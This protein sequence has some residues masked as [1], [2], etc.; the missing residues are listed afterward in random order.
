MNSLLEIKHL[1]KSYHKD[2]ILKDINIKIN[3]GDIYGLIGPNG[4]GKSTTVKTV[5]GLVKKDSGEVYFDGKLI[6]RNSS[7]NRLIG[8]TIEE[9]SFY[10][11]LSGYQNLKLHG[12][13][14]NL[15]DKRIDEVLELVDLKKVKDKKVNKYSMGMKQR[16]A[17]ARAFINKPELVIL[18]EPTNGLDPQGVLDMREF[19]KEQAEKGVTFIYCSHILSEVQN[20]CNRIGLIKEG[21]II[22][23]DRTSKL[24]SQE[25]NVYIIECEDKKDLIKYLKLNKFNANLI[26]NK[27]EVELENSSFSQLNQILFNS[28]FKID[29]ISKK[30][31]SLE[32]FFI[33]EVG[34]LND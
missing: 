3:R 25:K 16:L 13:L 7:M 9:P 4:S 28:N 10:E 23:E 27:V 34:G 18:D 8:A 31:F 24:L 29:D 1:Y 30:A 20:L 14:H 11:Y 5:L 26:D 19:I 32:S 15:P 12:N 6:N 33:R 22:A 17:V 21:V 2:Q